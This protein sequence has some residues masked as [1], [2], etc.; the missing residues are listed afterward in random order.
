[1]RDSPVD[2]PLPQETGVLLTRAREGDSNAL[3]AL[4]ERYEPRVLR[5]VR[6]RIGPSLRGRVESGDV[7]QDTMIEVMRSFVDFTPK[8][9]RSFLRW[10]SGVVENRMRNLWRSAQGRTVDE[11]ASAD[12]GDVPVIP[13][14]SGEALDRE[15]ERELL[16]QAMET[17]RDDFRRV[18]HLR[19]FARLSF[20][21]IGD[22]MGR[23]EDA[24]WALHKRA[25]AE[26][27]RTIHGLRQQG[28]S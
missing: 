1:M 15:L 11:L 5:I 9:E 8:D 26:L 18:V 22:Q 28:R 14:T 13:D 2:Q 16:S 10:I 20:Q 7:V 17:L 25:K 21:E 12:S 3:A 27:A 23:S 24:A 19:H 6:R 4:L